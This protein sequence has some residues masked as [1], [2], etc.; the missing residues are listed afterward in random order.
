M[1]LLSTIGE[2]VKIMSVC[3]VLKASLFTIFVLAVVSSYLVVSES[4]SADGAAAGTS[5]TDGGLEYTIGADGTVAITGLGDPSITELTI[6]SSVT[7][8]SVTYDVTSI[9]DYAFYNCTGLTSVTIPE[10]VTSIGDVAFYNCTGL[11][12]VTI[13]AS[14]T[15]IGYSAFYNCTGLTSVT[16]PEGVTS[17]GNY[18]FYNCIGMT[19][20]TIPSSVTAIGDYAFYNCTGL[21]SV[22]IPSSV[23]SIGGFAFGGLTFYAED[24][25]TILEQ[26]I[27]NLSGNSFAGTFD[28]LIR[29]YHTV[30]YDIGAGSL[31]APVQSPVAE[32][33]SFTLATY[34]GTNDGYV[35]VGWSDGTNVYAAGHSLTMGT[36]DI[37]LTAVWEAPAETNMTVWIAGALVAIIA[38]VLVAVFYVRRF[39]L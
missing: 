34:D 37:T 25:T 22:M 26:T 28:K 39:V 18:A 5:F 15:S 11:T 33:H 10:G 9:G 21:T 32:G 3:P 12:S 4:D 14:V 8:D 27:G 6:P 38:V 24:T 23:T 19:S 36:S 29:G 13:P 17:I 2:V 16:I 1:S 35:F 20:V 30:T 31:S 7:Y